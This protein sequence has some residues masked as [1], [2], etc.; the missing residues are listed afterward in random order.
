[1]K[2]NINQIDFF[3]KNFGSRRKKKTAARSA[4]ID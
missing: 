4:V 2:Q 1:M 3:Q